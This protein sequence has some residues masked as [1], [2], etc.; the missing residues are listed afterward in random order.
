MKILV[1]LMT[2][3]TV[4]VSAEIKTASGKSITNDKLGVTNIKVW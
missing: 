4:S 3:V 1:V 2:L